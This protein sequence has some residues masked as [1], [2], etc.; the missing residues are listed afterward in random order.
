[1]WYQVG[2]DIQCKA[3]NGPRSLKGTSVFNSEHSNSSVKV[4]VSWWQRLVTSFLWKANFINSVFAH[5]ETWP[6][7]IKK[8]NFTSFMK[9]PS[10]SKSLGNQS[11][12]VPFIG[13][14]LVQLL[15]RVSLPVGHFP[16][17]HVLHKSMVSPDNNCCLLHFSASLQP[18]TSL[19]WEHW[20]TAKSCY[21]AEFHKVGEKFPKKILHQSWTNVSFYIQ[22]V[23]KVDQKSV[24]TLR[25][26]EI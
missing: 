5:D 16:K 8:L 20:E 10:W 13:T 1:M 21:N 12:R 9:Q 14:E 26:P 22:R 25:E 3:L 6:V 18:K 7:G 24:E 23:R 2:T 19:C 17:D 15:L 11:R 4:R